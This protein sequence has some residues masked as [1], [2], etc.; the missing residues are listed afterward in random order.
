MSFIFNFPYDL[1]D[2][3]RD[4]NAQIGNEFLEELRTLIKNQ[5]DKFDF[6]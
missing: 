5:K 3:E 6:D 2:F 4:L 1:D